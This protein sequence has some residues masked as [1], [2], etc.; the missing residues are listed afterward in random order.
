MTT[1]ESWLLETQI[2]QRGLVTPRLLRAAEDFWDQCWNQDSI[3]LSTTNYDPPVDESAMDLDTP[4]PQ[5]RTRTV[6]MG[7]P[8]IPFVDRMLIRE[9]YA[10]ALDAAKDQFAFSNIAA[11]IFI[12][13]PGIGE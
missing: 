4:T 13:H 3:F 11:I 10:E 9:E 1:S 8:F 7:H 2:A 6:L 5:T 12:G